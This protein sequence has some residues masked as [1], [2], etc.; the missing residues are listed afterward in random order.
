MPPSHTRRSPE[1]RRAQLVDAALDVLATDGLVAFTLAR[2]AEVARVKSSLLI[3]YF[4]ARETLVREVL[5]LVQAH[6]RTVF[7][8]ALEGCPP[9]E[10]LSVVVGLLFEP[11]PE[12]QRYRRALSDA[13][14]SSY[15]EDDALRAYVRAVYDGLDGF[16]V[17]LLGAAF[18]EAPPAAHARVAYTLLCLSEAHR[19]FLVL[20][21]DPDARTA[22]VRAIAHAA[23]AALDRYDTP[24][25]TPLVA[26]R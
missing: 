16:L 10:A 4:G 1:A 26:P 24:G 11:T 3:H 7:R 21:F 20:G 6:Y 22:Q 14:A 25:Y 8:T 2:V 17:G 19:S 5:D 9:R 13:V 15:G 23:L 18:P 12:V